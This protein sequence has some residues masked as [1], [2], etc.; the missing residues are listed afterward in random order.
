M[1][2]LCAITIIIEAPVISFRHLQTTGN[3]VRTKYLFGKI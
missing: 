2:S 3:V 1:F